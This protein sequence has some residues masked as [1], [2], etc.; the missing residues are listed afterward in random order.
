MVFGYSQVLLAGY[1]LTRATNQDITL[2]ITL[3]CGARIAP[4]VTDEIGIHLAA[5][6][7]VAVM[8]L[9][10]RHAGLAFLRSAKR[11]KSAIPGIAILFLGV[12]EATFQMGEV[13]KNWAL[14][15][16]ALRGAIWLLI[17]LLFLMG[18]RIT[19]A[20]T[21]GTLQKR[22]L[23]RHGMSQGKLESCGLAALGTAALCDLTGFSIGLTTIPL[24]FVA[25]IIFLR[26][27][28]WHV[29]QA[30]DWL[31]VTS[32]H[33]GYAMLGIG[34]VFYAI[35]N[36]SVHN[37]PLSGFHG[38]MI[39]GLGILSIT[40]MSRTILQRLR[41]PVRLPI[42]IRLCNVLLFVASLSRMAAFHV[43]PSSLLTISATLWVLV[44]VG[45]IGVNGL[46]LWRFSSQN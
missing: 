17:T 16:S 34:L 8:G 5:A 27:I 36:I 33:L 24:L 20:A 26:L 9:L 43:F 31:D 3:W 1:L 32:L 11:L 25:L 30:W 28:Y 22:N 4:F 41:F 42:T 2:F 35:L 46:V 12:A 44:I 37:Q 45:F 38:T 40:V 18:G 10:F 6:C 29:W 15:E 13:L 7:N 14:Q 39:G 21:S 23:Y 19:A